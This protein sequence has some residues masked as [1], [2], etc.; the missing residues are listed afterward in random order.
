M[1]D[2]SVESLTEAE[3]ASELARLAAEMARHDALYADAAPEISDA[4][5][6]AL[7]AR[8]LAIETRFPALVREDSPSNKIGA[9]RSSQFAEVRHGVPMLS[10]DNAF[11]DGDVTEFVARI[12]RF[13]NLPADEKIAFVAEPKI[14]GLSANIRYENGILVQGATRGDGRAGEDITANLKTLK[15]IPHKLSGSGWPALIYVGG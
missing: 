12:R 9:P 11:D 1:A 15:D 14:D 5:Y 2:P 3:A 4:D 13:L 6:D 8:N 10:L 7:R